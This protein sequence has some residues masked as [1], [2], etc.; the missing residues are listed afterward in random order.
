VLI[1]EEVMRDWMLAKRRYWDETV[2]RQHLVFDRGVINMKKRLVII[3]LIIS[4]IFAFGLS[5]AIASQQSDAVARAATEAGVGYAV[6]APGDIVYL[7]EVTTSRDVRPS[8][9]DA[10]FDGPGGYY[11]LWIAPIY[12]GPTPD[13]LVAGWFNS[14]TDALNVSWSHNT[15]DSDNGE[16]DVST[17]EARETYLG[18]GQYYLYVVAYNYGTT[19]G[20]DSWRSVYNNN[21]DIYGDLTFVATDEN[22]TDPSAASVDNISIEYFDFGVAINDAD[23]AFASADH[24]PY[25]KANDDIA[26]TGATGRSYV[27]AMDDVGHSQGAGTI[28]HYDKYFGTVMLATVTDIYDVDHEGGDTTGWMWGVYYPDPTTPGL[29]NLDPKGEFLSADDYL[30]KDDALVVWVIG[31]LTGG[32]VYSDFF[33]STLNR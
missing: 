7:M 10:D 5:A 25:I 32:Y 2:G 26:P 15:P 31:K 29:Y 21:P 4:L 33:P 11:E 12:Q 23:D 22:D 6:A 3:G 9:F 8:T 1:G 20:P 19:L 18:S 17:M 14:A 13:D 24:Y 28:Q 30:L 16:I 27:T